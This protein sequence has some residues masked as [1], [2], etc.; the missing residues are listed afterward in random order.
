MSKTDMKKILMVSYFFPPLGGGGVQRTVKFVKY[1][2]KFGWKP[3]VLTTKTGRHTAMDESYVK[4]LSEEAEIIR[5]RYLGIQPPVKS[6]G[7]E[8]KNVKVHKPSFLMDVARSMYHNTQGL[9][10]IPDPQMLWRPLA[11]SDG[12]RAIRKNNIDCLYSTSAP[13]TSHLI[14]EDLHNLTGLP[15]VADFRD[16]WTLSAR[17]QPKT[18]LHKLIHENFERRILRN[19]SAVVYANPQSISQ[20]E[21]HF[22]EAQ[23]KITA[24]TNGF[25]SEDFVNTQYDHNGTITF[26]HMGS[27]YG[28]MYSAKKL[29]DLFN[30]LIPKLGGIR[31]RLRFIG[32]L[33]RYNMGLIQASPHFGKEITT[34]KYVPHE[35]SVRLVTQSTFLLSTIPYAK[36][37]EEEGWISQKIYEAMAS[38]R[39]QIAIARKDGETARIIEKTASGIVLDQ[40]WDAKKMASETL[41]FI[42][43]VRANGWH[44][45]M[46]ETAKQDYHRKNLTKKLANIFDGVTS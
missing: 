18:P 2:P 23:G 34:E 7:G 6:G 5:T 25:D 32:D 13:Y 10:F 22:K 45:A 3:Y 37:D 16:P 40:D 46:N 20:T 24:I 4:E 31:V 26:M 1:L 36:S 28:K 42:N 15:W 8:E 27:L 21:R 30:V 43:K 35:E 41:N 19:S 12:L 44:I 11:F 14:A 38:G 9:F 29:I 33:D 39:P 17:H